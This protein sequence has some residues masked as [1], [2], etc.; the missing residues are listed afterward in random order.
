MRIDN[1]YNNNDKEE[2][3]RLNDKNIDRQSEST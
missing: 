1:I 2:K 3:Y